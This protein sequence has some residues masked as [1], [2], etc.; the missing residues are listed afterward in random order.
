M[1]ADLK[2]GGPRE[3]LTPSSQVVAK[4]SGVCGGVCDPHSYG[5]S[6]GDVT[7][8]PSGSLGSWFGPG[9]SREVWVFPRDWLKLFT[10]SEPRTGVYRNSLLFSVGEEWS[11]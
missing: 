6:A 1:A 8:C 2:S 3:I 7:P 10:F 11:Q 5:H 9:W 4:T